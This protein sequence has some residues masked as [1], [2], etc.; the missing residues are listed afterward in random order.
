MSEEDLH[1]G[2]VFDKLDEVWWEAHN[3]IVAGDLVA[4]EQKARKVIAILQG[5]RGESVIGV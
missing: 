5:M 4:A 1:P 3:L 2:V